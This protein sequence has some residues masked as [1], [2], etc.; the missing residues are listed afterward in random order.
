MDHGTTALVILGVLGL[1]AL[2]VFLFAVGRS[3]PYD[4]R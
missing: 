4:H 3:I 2:A 1:L